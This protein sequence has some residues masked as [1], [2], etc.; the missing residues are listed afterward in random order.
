[1]F[2]AETFRDTLARLRKILDGLGIRFHLT[3]GVSTIAYGE[4]RMTQDVDVVVDPRALA[5]KV[6]E[7]LA[8][9]ESAGFLVDPETTRRAVAD[10]GM[11]QL[12]DLAE[13]LK[14]DLYPR[15]MIPG[16]LDRSVPVEVFAGLSLPIVARS[17][18]ALSKLIWVS[19]GSHKSRRDLRQI[20][21][22]ANAVEQG[23]VNRL[24]AE[25]GLASLLAEVLAESDAV[26]P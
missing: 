10:A 21:R 4:P 7:F 26:G 19:K 9:V 22:R 17:D 6:G 14:I 2:P 11:F 1:M 18:A 16:E 24:A 13:S 25:F 3:G 20:L 15:E 5:P 8:A 23:V 12:L